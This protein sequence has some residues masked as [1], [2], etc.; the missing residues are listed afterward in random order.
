METIDVVQAPIK[1]ETSFTESS[2]ESKVE[3]IP[4]GTVESSSTSQKTVSQSVESNVQPFGVQQRW[5][6]INI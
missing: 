1:N 6:Q 5:K 2:Q 4:N 3:Q